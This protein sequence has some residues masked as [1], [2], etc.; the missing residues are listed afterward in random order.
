[1]CFVVN[2]M[3]KWMCPEKGGLH[4]LLRKLLRWCVRVHPR[5]LQTEV[6][7]WLG[8]RFD[9]FDKFELLSNWAVSPKG[10]TTLINLS[11]WHCPFFHT[12][13]DQEL[14]TVWLHAYK[15]VL[16]IHT[17]ASTCNF[18]S[19][20]DMDLGLHAPEWS[21]M[22]G[23]RGLKVWTCNLE[24]GRLQH[25]NSA[26]RMQAAPP[27]SALAVASPHPALRLWLPGLPTALVLQIHRRTFATRVQPRSWGT[28][29]QFG[30]YRESWIFTSL[31]I[32]SHSRMTR[33]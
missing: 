10:H 5:A 27:A 15:G 18:D 8:H 33:M 2:R 12:C 20:T 1:M 22:Y 6:H 25:A 24:V 17:D 13:V 30:E 19:Q 9:K 14:I 32:S 4:F 31:L 26:W 7:Q 3:C 21:R 29:A 11:S 28:W 16:S 23:T